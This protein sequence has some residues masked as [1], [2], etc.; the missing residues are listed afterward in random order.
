VLY[1]EGWVQRGSGNDISF[2]D[3][4]NVIHIRVSAGPAPTAS[5]VATDLTRMKHSDPAVSFSPPTTVSLKAGSAI[6]S[7]YMVRSK[8]NSV[9]GK[10]LLLD[11]DRYVLS[12]AGKIATVDLSRAKGVDT[13]DAYRMIINSFRWRQ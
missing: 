9:T 10:T 2:S 8:P 3:K 5:R 12:H 6:R 11:V 4:T 1:P 7:T 13:A